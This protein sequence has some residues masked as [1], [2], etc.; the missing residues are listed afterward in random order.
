VLE[1]VLAAARSLQRMGR[2]ALSER[3]VWQSKEEQRFRITEYRALGLAPRADDD[4]VVRDFT[5]EAA[6]A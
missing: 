6:A 4:E 5:D 1:E 2:I 3:K